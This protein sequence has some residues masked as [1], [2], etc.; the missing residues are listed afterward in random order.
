MKLNILALMQEN[1]F[2]NN[3]S[4]FISGTVVLHA[5]CRLHPGSFGINC[6]NTPEGR[7]SV[8][9]IRYQTFHMQLPATLNPPHVVTFKNEYCGAL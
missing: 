7:T 3:I 6:V 1:I 4:R 5:M 8:V 2:I 9:Q